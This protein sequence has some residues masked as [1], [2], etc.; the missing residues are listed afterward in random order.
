MAASYK[1]YK[2]TVVKM[3]R[4]SV[5][6]PVYNGEPYLAE[7][8]DCIL[9]Q[10]F[11][12][13][14][15]IIINDGSKDGSAAC[16]A[17]FSDPRIRYFEQP[18]AGLAATLNRG[19]SLAAGEYIARQ[20]QD[21]IS[22]PERFAAQTA[23]LDE[24]PD[25]CMVGTWAEIFSEA[26]SGQRF[27]RHPVGNLELKLYLHFQNPFVHSSMMLRTSVVRSIGGYTTDKSRQPPEDYE[28]WSR[29]ARVGKVANIPH[30]LVK[31]REVCSSM[32]RGSA[33]DPFRPMVHK[34][35]CENMAF[36]LEGCNEAQAGQN[37]VSLLLQY[38]QPLHLRSSNAEM[39][40]AMRRLVSHICAAEP[41]EVPAL[42]TKADCFLKPYL[43]RAVFSRIPA[44]I[45]CNPL[46]QKLKGPLRRL[47]NTLFS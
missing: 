11:T 7:A 25:Y 35:A 33:V 44:G 26:E 10:T 21:D 4:I 14:E 34:I 6:L 38:P 15:V 17:Q 22:F 8:I 30:I 37:L 39:R 41:D 31:Y 27:H 32:S 29:M 42:M 46:I 5:I 2:S 45:R 13:F 28:L 20:D 19:I 1:K 3:P 36:S 18:N 12:D 43:K 16:I 24:Y 40:Q 9:G 23:F 47:Y